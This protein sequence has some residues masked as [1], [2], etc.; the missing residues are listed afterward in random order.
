MKGRTSNKSSQSPYH[1]ASDL[2][3]RILNKLESSSSSSS[4]SKKSSS[5]HSNSGTNYTQLLKSSVTNKEGKLQVSSKTYA[6]VAKVLQNKS[7]IDTL[8]TETNMLLPDSN[9][10]KNMGLFYIMIYEL[11]FA[12]SSITSSSSSPKPPNGTI[13]GGGTVK[14]YI[15]QYESILREKYQEYYGTIIQ[16]ESNE[17]N[18]FDDDD[19]DDDD[20]HPNTNHHRQA[21]PQYHRYVRVNTCVTTTDEFLQLYLTMMNT[22]QD[23]N[24]PEP[25]SK[26]TTS[27]T[28]RIIYRDE[29]VSDLFVIP[30]HVTSQLLS[31]LTEQ[32]KGNHIVLQD[33]SSCIPAYCLYSLLLHQPQQSKNIHVLD[34][35]AAP[36]NKTSHIAALLLQ[37]PSSTSPQHP[38]NSKTNPTTPTST[39]IINHKVCAM[40]RDQERCQILQN[41]MKL[42]VPNQSVIPTTTSNSSSAG[43]DVRVQNKDFLTISGNGDENEYTNL[44]CIVLDPSCS[45]SGLYHRNIFADDTNTRTT[46]EHSQYLV[47]DDTQQQQRI[48][49]LSNFQITCLRHALTSFPNVHT[50]IYSTCSTY[51]MENEKVV[52]SVFGNHHNEPENDINTTNIREEW[53]IVA[54]PDLQNWKRRGVDLRP[55]KRNDNDNVLDEPTPTDDQDMSELYGDLTNEE[56]NCF[57]RTNYEDRTN[58]FFVACFQRKSLLLNSPGKKRKSKLATTKQQDPLQRDIPI[59]NGEFDHMV[60]PSVSDTKY[61]GKRKSHHPL[62]EATNDAN[63]NGS[64]NLVTSNVMVD[65]TSPTNK[66]RKLENK[67]SGKTKPTTTTTSTATTT[68]ASSTTNGAVPTGTTNHSKKRAKKLEWKQRQHDAKL[69]R[70]KGEK[71]PPRK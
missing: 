41:R 71:G 66:K 18:H 69:L 19:D 60:R 25:S 57:I 30:S 17:K 50:V 16:N 45:G 55:T 13:K 70:T 64:E 37:L 10:I 68:S 5:H 20:E 51:I 29:H 42:L 26:T 9:P 31:T 34:A 58:G 28:E 27:S 61:N 23:E 33:K 24:I 67:S 21:Q 54:P 65:G 52:A 53:S 44:T 22:N 46:K 63:E 59:Y 48:Q 39:N 6:I 14:R 32:K 11:L 43:V 2:L 3:N 36:G 15:L 12:S 49:K 62:P 1:E 56:I 8:I 35:C 47:S 4:K 38:P 40:D 7:K